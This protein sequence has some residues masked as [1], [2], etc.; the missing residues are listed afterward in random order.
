MKTI[1]YQNVTEGYMT[2]DLK[3][4][5]LIFLAE[6]SLKRLWFARPWPFFKTIRTRKIAGLAIS[7]KRSEFKIVDSGFRRFH[8]SGQHEH[9]DG[10]AT[11]S[12]GVL[13]VVGY[14]KDDP[15]RRLYAYLVSWFLNSWNPMKPDKWTAERRRIVLELSIPVVESLVRTLKRKEFKVDG[16]TKKISGLLFGGDTNSIRW[17]GKLDGLHHVWNHGLDRV[18]EADDI[19]VS[20]AGET[21]KTGQG[22]Q[23]QHNG[24]RLKQHIRG[25]S[26]P[27]GP[28]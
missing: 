4:A 3:K 7:V 5:A 27:K 2:D 25:F 14:W 28:R 13:W 22:G 6:V 9:W 17:D 23:M 16:K 19:S 18:W 8:G 24:I 10:I 1:V 15:E 20:F 11:P 12:R 26:D 21:P